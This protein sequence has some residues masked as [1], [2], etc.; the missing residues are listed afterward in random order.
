MNTNKKYWLKGGIITIFVF[1][2]IIFFDIGSYL[3]S[4]PYS[5]IVVWLVFGIFMLPGMYASHFLLTGSQ[6]LVF[7]I[8]F[9]ISL[10]F[11]FLLG[12]TIGH[13]YGKFKNK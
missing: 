6:S 1:I 3:F 11:W 7:W 12:A 10:L 2:L 9:A 13:V 4:N 5:G 8:S